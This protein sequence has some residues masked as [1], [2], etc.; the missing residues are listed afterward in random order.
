MAD[1]PKLLEAA[2]RWQS[3]FRSPL[4]LE[5]KSRLAIITCMDSRYDKLKRGPNLYELSGVRLVV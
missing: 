3:N 2:S 1:V 4:P 5:A